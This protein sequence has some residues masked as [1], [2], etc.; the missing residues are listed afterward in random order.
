MHP[1]RLLAAQ[2]LSR[3]AGAPLIARQRRRNA[4][5]C[6]SEFDANGSRRSAGPSRASCSRTTSSAMTRSLAV[7]AMPWSI[8]LRTVLRVHVMRDWLG[9]LGQSSRRFWKPLID[10]GG[11]VRTYNAPRLW[12]PLRLAIPRPPK[13]ARR[14]CACRLSR[15][16]LR[17]RQV[18]GRSAAQHSALARYRGRCARTRLARPRCRVCGNLVQPRC[19]PCRRRCHAGM[20]AIEARRQHRSSRRRY[21]AECRR[22][23]SARPDD[24]CDGGMPA[25]G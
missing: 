15:R 9:C 22:T 3:T 10:A 5:R 19:R 16:H 24:R 2:A 4:D 1:M 17:Q 25:C 20:E 21:R 14:R 23:L 18:A 7:C 11:E 8:G 13:V 6:A 12:K